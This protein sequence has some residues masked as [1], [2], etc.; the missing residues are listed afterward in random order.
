MK[1]RLLFLALF[2]AA[3]VQTLPAQM[4]YGFNSMRRPAS[5][6]ELLF[7]AHAGRTDLIPMAQEGGL[8][9]GYGILS[10][11]GQVAMHPRIMGPARMLGG[12]L[13][14]IGGGYYTAQT[15]GLGGALGGGL[16]MANGADN[17]WAGYQMT[18]TGQYQQAFLERGL[19]ST[20]GPGWGTGAYAA[21]QL[22]MVGVP[23][24]ASRLN[25]L[26]R[27]PI[28][29]SIIPDNLPMGSFSVVDWSGYPSFLPRPTGPMRLLT[30]DE[31]LAARRAADS[32]NAALR[33]GFGL[34]GVGMDVHEILPIK[35]GGS[36]V[37][38]L[39]KMLLPSY[40]HRQTVTPFWNNL[41]R[42]VEPFVIDDI[43]DG[44]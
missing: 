38:P 41:Q 37:D 23:Y 14:A 1:Y 20:L 10:V 2:V 6:F 29:P 11:P 40:L 16:L 36:P 15:G 34:R 22:G 26:F 24:G 39:N 3:F 30:G 25:G 4:P 42:N 27:P 33:E 44:L 5:P 17:F 21:T 35:F 13:E 8:Y 12:G 19:T 43:M 32:T 28:P 31:Y 18:V 9:A 7:P